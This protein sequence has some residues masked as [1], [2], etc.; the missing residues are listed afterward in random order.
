MIEILRC[1]TIKTLHPRFQPSVVVIDV[2]DVIKPLG[3]D[4]QQQTLTEPKNK[5]MD[6][7]HAFFLRY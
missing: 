7:I 4:D 6:P 3:A 2:L 1:S 5:S